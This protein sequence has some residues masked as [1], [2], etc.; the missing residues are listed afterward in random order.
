MEA[1]QNQILKTE[2]SNLKER[3]TMHLCWVKTRIYSYDSYLIDFKLFCKEEQKYY[4]GAFGKSSKIAK[5]YLNGR[6][7]DKAQFVQEIKEFLEKNFTEILA[8]DIKYER[9]VYII[10]SEER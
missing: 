9:V 6:Y 2:M 1:T 8:R 4:I 3:K 7:A 10:E 5:K